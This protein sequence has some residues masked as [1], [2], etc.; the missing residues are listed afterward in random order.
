MKKIKLAV[1]R[2]NK[3]RS[4]PF[5]LPIIEGC[6]CAGDSVHRMAPIGTVKGKEQLERIKKA[7]S[8]VYIHYKTG[9]R[10]LYADKVLEKFKKVDCDHGDTGQ[11]QNSV[12]YRGSPLYPRTFSGIG[13]D[14][15]YGYPLGMY[16]DN[17]ES[18]NIFFGLFSFLGSEKPK[19]LIKLANK[20][21][22]SG[23]KEKADIIDKI[24]STVKGITNKEEL[25]EKM[26]DIE[27]FLYKQRQEYEKGRTDSG[28]LFELFE[29]WYGPRQVIR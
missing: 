26:Q 11:G 7:N 20:Y 28:I 10:C 23:E 22:E 24:L 3:L 17:N 16:S 12:P 2:D 13:L 14:G 4:C 1:I 8:L 15:I 5:G 29:R 18:R 25:D 9:K 19:E 21:D 6:Q 27:D